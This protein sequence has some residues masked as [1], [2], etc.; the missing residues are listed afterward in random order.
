[1]FN[2]LKDRYYIYIHFNKSYKQ[3]VEGPLRVQ[4]IRMVKVEEKAMKTVM[5]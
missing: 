2:I 4:S 3:Q 5:T 1:M